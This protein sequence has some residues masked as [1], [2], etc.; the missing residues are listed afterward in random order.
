MMFFLLWFVVRHGRPDWH[1]IATGY[2]LH[3]WWLG[4]WNLDFGPISR[5]FEL[6]LLEVMVN[7]W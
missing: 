4:H 3:H 6:V 5:L 1:G 2:T 7:K